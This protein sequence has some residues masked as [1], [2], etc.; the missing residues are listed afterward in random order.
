M[1]SGCHSLDINMIRRRLESTPLSPKGQISVS[2]QNNMA[3]SQ[4]PLV[5]EIVMRLKG[6]LKTSW[7]V[8]RVTRDFA[9]K[10]KLGILVEQFKFSPIS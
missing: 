9:P 7:D 4:S 10:H 3:D 1:R 5:F 2:C 6:S 8:Y